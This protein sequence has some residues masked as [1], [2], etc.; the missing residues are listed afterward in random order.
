MIIGPITIH[1]FETAITLMAFLAPPNAAPTLFE[2]QHYPRLEKAKQTF[3][4][5]CT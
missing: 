2:V 5:F 3:A 4:F 1:H